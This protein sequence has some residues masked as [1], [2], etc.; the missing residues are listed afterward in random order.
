MYIRRESKR[1]AIDGSISS[2]RP[3]DETLFNS[4]RVKPF[5]GPHGELTSFRRLASWISRQGGMEETNGGKREEGSIIPLPPL[6]ESATGSLVVGLAVLS[7]LYVR[8]R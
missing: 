4:K 5:G 2:H 3:R 8:R 1:T 6:A 7:E